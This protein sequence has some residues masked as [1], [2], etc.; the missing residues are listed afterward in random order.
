MSPLPTRWV[1]LQ[2]F[3]VS[4]IFQWMN[5]LNLVCNLKPLMLILLLNHCLS[6]WFLAQQG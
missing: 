1:Q 4:Q 3:E 2:F 6:V 5:S